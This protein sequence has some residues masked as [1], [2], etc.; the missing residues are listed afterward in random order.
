MEKTKRKGGA[1]RN[2]GAKP[3]A[4]QLKA[5]ELAGLG[6]DVCIA[7]LKKQGE[8]ADVEREVRIELARS[9]AV[10]AMP[11]IVEGHVT[12]EKYQEI[13]YKLEEL[14]TDE[15]RSLITNSRSNAIQKTPS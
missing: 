14:T 13:V 4:D 3:Y 8:Y 7:V 15:L 5:R 9:V 6:I 2:A 11:N 1:R 10:K 12:E